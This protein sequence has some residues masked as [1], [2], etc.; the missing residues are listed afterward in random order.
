LVA[1][2]AIIAIYTIVTARTPNDTLPDY[3]A[4]PVRPP[5]DRRGALKIAAMI[6]ITV[7]GAIGAAM[8]YAA[9]VAYS[10]GPIYVLVGMLFLIPCLFLYR[11]LTRYSPARRSDMDRLT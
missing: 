6:G 7:F 4:D 1:G 3:V 11:Y 2:A 8:L 9:T 5:K 10:D